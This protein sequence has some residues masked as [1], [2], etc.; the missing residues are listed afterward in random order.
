MLDE[1]IA[2]P[3]DAAPAPEPGASPS[4]TPSITLPADVATSLKG[5][6]QCMPGD[7]YTLSVAVKAVGEDGSL[8]LDVPPDATFTPEVPAEPL[9]DSAGLNSEDDSMDRT[10]GPTIMKGVGKSLAE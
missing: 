1:P 5:E 10:S 4:P 7:R 9:G 3:S 8:T 6:H 2:P